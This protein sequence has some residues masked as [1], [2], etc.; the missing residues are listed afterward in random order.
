MENKHAMD[1]YLFSVLGKVSSDSKDKLVEA[2][3]DRAY[4][5]ASSRVSY[6]VG[7]KER[8]DKTTEL[9]KRID[10]LSRACEE[11]FS[12]WHKE[13]CK[14]ILP[15]NPGEG[16]GYGKAQKWLNMTMKYLATIN[17][18]VSSE[19]D[20]F[21]G[22]Y[23]GLAKYERSFHIPID[24]YVIQALCYLDEVSASGESALGLPYKEKD[25]LPKTMAVRDCANPH[26]Y[27]KA[28]SKWTEDDYYSFR[29]KL[30]DRFNLEWESKVWPMVAKCRNAIDSIPNEDGKKKEADKLRDNLR[31]EIRSI[32]SWP[33]VEK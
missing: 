19:N 24:S 20:D 10:A 27:V 31:K 30:D 22:F 15:G 17:A 26:D 18:L 14:V 33:L 23:S 11:D 21:K 32:S 7:D 28:W 12:R 25:K 1:F 2:A 8:Q 5:D 29:D 16:D 13:T 3:I 9:R 4:R 6:C